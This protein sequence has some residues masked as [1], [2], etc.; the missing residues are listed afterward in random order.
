MEGEPVTPDGGSQNPSEGNNPQADNG[1]QGVEGVPRGR[2]N[3]SKD[4]SGGGTV[5]GGA[6]GNQQ[7]GQK[8]S[9]A[10]QRGTGDSGPER[11]ER[12]GSSGVSVRDKQSQGFSEHTS[13][14]NEVE[15]QSSDE[16]T[17]RLKRQQQVKDDTPIKA[18]DEANIAETLPLLYSEQHEDIKAIEKRLYSNG[19][20]GMLVANG[21]GTG[22]TLTALGVIKRQIMNGKKKI[23][24]IVPSQDIAND[25]WV[26]DGKLLGLDEFAYLGNGKTVDGVPNIISYSSLATNK[27][28]Q[29]VDWDLIIC[30]EA[31][32]IASGQ[33]RTD[34]NGKPEEIGVYTTAF[35]GLFGHKQGGLREYMRMPKPLLME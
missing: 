18:A 7:G 20:P 9:D 8:T 4:V 25:A 31:H 16:A 22:K 23:L 11:G 29:E 27:H 1:E 19:K 32:H 14:Q 35:R 30:D 21:T 10:S 34:V 26:K 5:A 33:K 2:A 13:G 17:E 24:I 15:R 28:V 12:T 6:R 3:G